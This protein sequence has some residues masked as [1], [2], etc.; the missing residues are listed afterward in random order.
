M[1]NQ[2]FQSEARAPGLVSV[3]S[4]KNKATIFISTQEVG[5]NDNVHNRQ[6]YGEIPV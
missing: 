1:G 6:T 3:V 4:G 2:G 5:D